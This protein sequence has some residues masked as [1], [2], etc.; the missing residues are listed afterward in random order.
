NYH[1]E[2]FSLQ[3]NAYYKDYHKLFDDYRFEFFNRIN[4][5]AIL[6]RPFDTQSGLSKGIELMAR[7]Q[8]GN[9]LLMLSYALAEN[10]IY[11]DEGEWAYRDFDQRHSVIAENIFRLPFHWN[12]SLLWRFHTG[13]PYTPSQVNFV[14]V[15]DFSDRSI[16]FYEMGKKNSERLPNVHS[17]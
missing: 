6:D 11:N 8:Y 4:G 16:M 3:V 10:K 9:N 5:V 14:G 17:L 1:Q 2:N 13:H 7:K 12:I 15:S